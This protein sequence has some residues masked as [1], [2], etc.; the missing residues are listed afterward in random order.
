MEVR[1]TMTRSANAPLRLSAGS[2]QYKIKTEPLKVEAAC[3]WQHYAPT[4]T[5]GTLKKYKNI[6]F[7]QILFC[8][9]SKRKQKMSSNLPTPEQ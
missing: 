5:V 2:V 6:H 1:S 3:F 8:Q 7:K 9:H 4:L